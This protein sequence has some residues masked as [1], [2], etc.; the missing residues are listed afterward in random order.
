LEE[1]ALGVEDDREA[2]LDQP[3]FRR[4]GVGAR[5]VH[6]RA[7]PATGEEF[8]RAA[9]PGVEVHRCIA[10][11]HRVGRRV[12]YLVAPAG[13]TRTQREVGQEGAP[14][15]TLAGLRVVDRT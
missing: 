10:P 8:D 11:G 5:A 7:P 3:S 13:P 4:P 15:G 6:L 14:C 12:E 1:G 9:Q 2:L